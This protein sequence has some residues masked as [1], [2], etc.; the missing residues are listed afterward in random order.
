ML[1]VISELT[2]AAAATLMIMAL[3]TGEQGGLQAMIPH[4][5]G[6]SF[7]DVDPDFAAKAQQIFNEWS[8]AL[9]AGIGWIWILTI[10]AIAV[11]ANTLLK[12][13]DYALRPSLA[14]ET[15]GLPGWLLL[16][17]T[18]SGML[19]MVGQGVE[20]FTAEALFLLLLL[21]YCLAGIAF[22]HLFSV[23]RQLHFRRLWITCFYVALIFGRWPIL[24]MIAIGLYLQ[25]AE[26]LDR[27]KKMG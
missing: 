17:V 19:A 22:V 16:L 10:Y 24:A 12:L 2:I 8:F 11:L 5:L 1:R 6:E 13:K 9:F 21:P 3:A 25:L 4:G 27:R 26:M 20:R 14:L 18:L 15:H 7:K 23:Q